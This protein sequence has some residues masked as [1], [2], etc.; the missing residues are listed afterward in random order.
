MEG[1]KLFTQKIFALKALSKKKQSD[2]NLNLKNQKQAILIN[3]FYIGLM[4]E[5][6]TDKVFFFFCCSCVIVK[7]KQNKTCGEKESDE[8]TLNEVVKAMEGE[9]RQPTIQK[10]EHST[11]EI[12]ERRQPEQ[13][14]KSKLLQTVGRELNSRSSLSELEHA[15]IIFITIIP[16]SLSF[17]LSLCLS[18]FFTFK[19]KTIQMKKL[20]GSR[21]EGR[22][23]KKCIIIIIIIIGFCFWEGVGILKSS[24]QVTKEQLQKSQ[25][26]DAIIPF[27]F[28]KK[29]ATIPTYNVYTYIH[30]YVYVCEYIN[31][32]I[33]KKKKKMKM[34]G[35]MKSQLQL[36]SEQLQR[37]IVRDTLKHEMEDRATS[38]EQMERDGIYKTPMQAAR[39][40]LEKS[41]YRDA[42]KRDL[43]RRSSK[44]GLTQAGK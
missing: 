7:K 19:C 15:G 2:K 20:R 23:N 35:I 22:K 29:C 5:E 44:S 24:L 16:L 21:R 6:I 37:S 34:A 3:Q 39:E 1:E 30:I 40:Q 36:N 9:G 41:Q 11:E 32:N 13:L 26:K 38:S 43:R 33:K 10:S 18:P 42:I 31:N 28:T 14:E 12:N 27:F 17:S 4:A 25:A 8:E